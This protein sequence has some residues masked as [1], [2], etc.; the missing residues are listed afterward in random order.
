MNLAWGQVAPAACQ[1][2]D[3]AARGAITQVDDRAGGTRPITQSPYRFSGARS[4]VRGPAP[5]EVSI[6]LRFLK[7][8]WVS[9]AQVKALHGS[10]VLQFDDEFVQL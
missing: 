6:T 3:S 4:G 5:T 7:I 1:A 2:A 8:G 10:G 9:A